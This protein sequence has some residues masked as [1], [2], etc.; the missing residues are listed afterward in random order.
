MAFHPNYATNGY[1]YVYY[2]DKIVSPGDITIARYQRLGQ[3]RRRRSGLGADPARRPAPD[4]HEPQRRTALLRPDDGYLYAG[5]GDGGGGGDPPNNAQNLDVL[6]GKLLRIDVNGTG[7]IPCGQATPMPYAIPASNPFAG[8][9]TTATRSGP[10]ACATRGAIASTASTG[11]LL[12]GDVGQ[13]LYEEIDFQ[14]AS[15]A[16][17]ENYGWHKMEGFHCYDPAP[18]ATTA[19]S[20]LP[21]LEHDAPGR[22]VRDHRR[23]SGTAARRSP[24]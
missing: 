12:I 18:T 20:T 3:S 14:P 16:G 13:E 10:T 2:T 23:L 22:L 7:A 11:D 9:A 5:T 24:R 21:I 4:Q 8:S 6:L 1:F 17:G 15:S 19:R